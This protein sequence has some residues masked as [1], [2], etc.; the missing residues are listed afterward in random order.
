AHLAERYVGW[1]N[2]P[3]VVRYSE[4]RH[5]RHSMESCRRYVRAMADAGNP[6]W[7]II[8]VDPALGHIGN[9]SANL[10]LNN[11]ICDVTILIG[12]R[13]AW[14]RGLGREAWTAVCDFML[15]PGAMR[16]VVGGAMAAN[17]AMIRIMERSA[18]Q[19]DGSRPRHY[20]LDGVETDV[21]YFARYRHK[22]A[23][24]SGSG[25]GAVRQGSDGAGSERAKDAS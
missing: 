14:G 21:V 3:E 11:R 2:D 25:T 16:K 19:P 24:S 15:G 5:H 8:A 12:E 18:M 17:R 6:L 20:L 4:Q 22:V 7:A 9:I 23:E 13:S 1:L 10:D